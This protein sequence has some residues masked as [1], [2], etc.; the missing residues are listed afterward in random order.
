MRRL[1]SAL[2]LA[3]CAAFSAAALVLTLLCSVELTR[4]SGETSA[5]EQRL[6][7]AR[8]ESGRLR[9]E[10]ET[11][12]SLQELER[13]AVEELGMQTPGAGQIYHIAAEQVG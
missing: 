12:I 10:L 7:Q 2:F 4:L 13:R 5:L 11:C 1:N 8:A 6:E 9:A 3:V